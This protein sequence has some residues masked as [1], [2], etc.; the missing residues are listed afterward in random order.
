MR[1]IAAGLVCIVFA[2]APAAADPALFPG[3]DYGRT[4]LPPR[5]SIDPSAARL[6]AVRD[7]FEPVGLVRSDDALREVA[8]TVVRLDRLIEL[9]GRFAT[10]TCT[11]TV[12]APDLV[13][14]SDRCI[15]G[16]ER[17][18]DASILLNYEDEDDPDAVRLPVALAPVAANEAL[19]F[20]FV[21]ILAPLPEGTAPLRL[22]PG[23]VGPGEPLTLLHHPAGQPKTM[24]TSG[25]KPDGTAPT[26]PMEL[27]HG[28]ATLPGSIG[29]LIVDADRRPVG[30]HRT[31]GLRDDEPGSHNVA[32]RTDAIR[33]A[34]AAIDAGSTSSQG[35][36]GPSISPSVAAE[37]RGQTT[38]F[39]V[40]NTP[41]APSAATSPLGGPTSPAGA[42]PTAPVPPQTTGGQFN[43]LLPN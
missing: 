27:T 29:G 8:D 26:R 40:Q 31:D 2:S 24:T 37:V 12:V 5:D 28:C 19:G 1:V 14:T 30:M 7:T 21:R 10:S 34:L 11:G 6:E 43:P 22:T 13:L 15:P 18:R 25:C 38:N 16:T 33:D 4:T 9:D 20:A 32:T 41:Q 23:V 42:V 36:A 3:S 17:V 35:G 39:Q